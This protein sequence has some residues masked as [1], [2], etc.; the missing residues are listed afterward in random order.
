MF[1]LSPSS[2][3]WSI[4]SLV[5]AAFLAVACVEPHELLRDDGNSGGAGSFAQ[6]AAS[7]DENLGGAGGRGGAEAGGSGGSPS[8][9]ASSDSSTCPEMPPLSGSPCAEVGASAP[10]GI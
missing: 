5:A 9:D 3:S 4:G 2:P 8:T 1:D 7:G 6:D 10:S